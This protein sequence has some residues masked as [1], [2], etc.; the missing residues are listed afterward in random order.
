MTSKNLDEEN[1]EDGQMRRRKMV[2]E[3]KALVGL[4]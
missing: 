4:G 3:M 1:R 2:D